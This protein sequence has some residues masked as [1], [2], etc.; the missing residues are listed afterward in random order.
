MVEAVVAIALV[1]IGISSTVAALTKM[2]AF[3]DVS[4]NATGAYAAV[5]NQI[6]KI[7]SDSPFNPLNGQVPA[8]L[9][10][11]TSI[12]SNVP[13]YKDSATNTIVSGTMTTTVTDASTTWNGVNI[14]RYCASVNVTYIYLNR[15]Y[16]FTMNT[17]RASD[18]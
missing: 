18:E 17:I 11:G 13:I 1:G 6:D 16:S 10:L 15:N 4:R 5:M 9:T 8:E 7:Q 3:A 14:V 12:A 2:N